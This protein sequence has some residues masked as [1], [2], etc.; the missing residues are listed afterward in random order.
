MKFKVSDVAKAAN[1][2]TATVSRVLNEVPTVSPDIRARVLKSIAELNFKP[3][4]IARSLKTMKTNT[5][6][7]VV[8]DISNQFFTE[9]ARQVEFVLENA[10]YDMLVAST[11]SKVR[12]ENEILSML[13]AKSVDGIILSP[14]SNDL[15]IVVNKL[16]CPVVAVDRR[17][18]R[19]VCDSV[20]VDKGVQMELIV[21]YLF[22]KGHRRIA[23]VSGEQEFLLT[24]IEFLDIIGRFKVII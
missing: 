10:G 16:S 15:S 14:E 3:N 7:V 21:N 5:I 17:S 1:V 23:L 11:D 13:D 24:R 4:S 20:Y 2:S 9:L 19:G 6:A 8:S 22:Q 12:R 18:L